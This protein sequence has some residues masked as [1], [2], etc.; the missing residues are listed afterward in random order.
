M[1]ILKKLAEGRIG[2]LGCTPREAS[3][4]T[5][6]FQA[7]QPNAHGSASW[8]MMPNPSKSAGKTSDLCSRPPATDCLILRRAYLLAYDGPFPLRKHLCGAA[9][10]LFRPRRTDPR[11]L[12]KTDQAEPAAC[13]PPRPR[14]GSAR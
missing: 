2:E 6:G 14:S 7:R 13:D 12:P 4:F 10:E 8:K 5:R 1:E 3:G 11:D 9:G